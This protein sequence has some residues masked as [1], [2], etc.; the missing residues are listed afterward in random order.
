M[1]CQLGRRLLALGRS[2]SAGIGILSGVF[3]RFGAELSMSHRT[4]E[5]M[6]GMLAAGLLFPSASVGVF[7]TKFVK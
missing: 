5:E 3:K 7:V 1:Q 6:I 2:R 4:L